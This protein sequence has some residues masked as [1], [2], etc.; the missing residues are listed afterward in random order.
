MEQI[1]QHD[2]HDHHGH[3]H[4]HHQVTSVNTAF[5][6]GIILNAGFVVVEL[7]LGFSSSSLALISDAGH[8]ATDV[9]SLLLSLFA[10]KMMKVKTSDKYTYGYKKLSILTSLLNAI[11]LVITTVVIFYEGFRRINSPVEIQGKMVS[12]V[13]FI[14]IAVNAISAWLFFRNKE[15]DINIKGA[16]LHLLSDALVALGVVI[17][18]LVI[19]FTNWFWLDT[20]ISFAIGII[21]L[22][23]T[24]NLLNE[25]I[26]L[27]L[28]GI[29]KDINLEM[30]KQ[31]ILAYE[32]VKKIYHI[33]IWP[34]SSSEN[35]MTA[36]IEVAYKDII[37]FNEVKQEIKHKLE[38]I[39]IHHSTL[40][41][42][43][44]HT[45]EDCPVRQ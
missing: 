45:A 16:Y 36:H 22:L 26:R 11:L 13:A 41:I 25:S 34:I 35:A 21:I 5:I 18:G 29:P 1:H 10:F 20:V 43:L 37:A 3:H 15:K 39:N 27:S 31:T 12:L 2:H 6:I 7:V 14:G 32:V 23:A 28:D 33:H 9:F 30:V 19:Y 44:Q 8:N 4:G 17:A 40:E 42:E 24:W 38:H